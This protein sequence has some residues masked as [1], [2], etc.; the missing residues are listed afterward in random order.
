[1]DNLP[2]FTSPFL[3]TYW[4]Y[5]VNF[6]LFRESN[7]IKFPGTEVSISSGFTEKTEGLYIAGRLTQNLKLL[8]RLKTWSLLVPELGDSFN[9]LPQNFSVPS[10][11]WPDQRRKI[12]RTKYQTK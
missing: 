11:K 1:M 9:V 8:I 5:R 2:F 4:P 3:E 12:H 7:S 6:S 10:R